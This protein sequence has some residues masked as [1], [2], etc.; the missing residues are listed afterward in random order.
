MG[1]M[2]QLL[3]RKTS[4]IIILLLLLIITAASTGVAYYF[5]QHYQQAQLLLRDPDAVAREEV[6]NL[7][8]Q[9]GKFIELPTNEEPTVATVSDKT[10]LQD[11]PFFA[12]AENGDKV[13]IYTQNK[14][15]ILYR[16]S[17]NKIIEVAPI[18]I[19]ESEVVADSATPTPSLAPLRLALYNGTTVSGLTKKLEEELKQ[20]VP[21][22][23]VVAKE[24]A[25]NTTYKDTLVI[26]LTGNRG[27]EAQQIAEL[28]G[29]SVQELPENENRPT[30]ADILV[31]IG[32]DKLNT[33]PAP[34][35]SQ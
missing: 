25:K 16:P 10:K 8:D 4:V 29:G 34:A 28:L 15:A 30:D 23:T 2:I 14:K 20:Q 7:V 1:I 26:D 21:S 6:K 12:R 32:E 27:S 9:V 31:I 33:S 22:A 18:N 5:Y 11:Q 24:N 35:A 19:G 3:Q 13:F 17:T